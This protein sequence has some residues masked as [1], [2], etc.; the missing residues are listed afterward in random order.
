MLRCY[1]Q[2]ALNKLTQF[3]RQ[4]S[5]SSTFIT[6]CQK[7]DNMERMKPLEP[8][9]LDENAAERWRKWKQRWNLYSKASGAVEKDE[10]TQC[11][12]FLH[13]I[14][15]D[16]LEIYDTF[17]FTDEE[18]GKINALIGKFE[19]HCSPKKN[20]TYERYKFNTCSQ[21]GRPLDVF[22]VD[23]RSKAKTCEF[24]ELQNSLIRDRIVCGIDNNA[25]RER[26]LRDNALTLDK[27]IST[28]RAAE[29]SQAQVKNLTNQPIETATVQAIKAN[30]K[31]GPQQNGKPCRRCGTKHLINQCPAYGQ[32]CLKCQGKN[33]YAKMCFSS[34]RKLYES[35]NITY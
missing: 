21:N 3:S 29:T 26:L 12:I 7:W 24:G 5:C 18:K 9:I 35:Q 27:A 17:T 20:I 6:W 23:L 33:H 22:L 10:E 25:V 1:V 13:M 28:V 32:T 4:L 31:S 14:G 8:L 34:R 2:L 15:D 30:P 19:E 11:A 16:A